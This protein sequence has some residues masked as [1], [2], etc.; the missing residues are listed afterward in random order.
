MA[1]FFESTYDPRQRSGT[2]GAEVS[3][4]NPEQAYDTDVRRLDET[5]RA[6][7]DDVDI[8]NLRQ[9]NR[10]SRFMAAAKTA[11]AYRQRASI[12]E[13]QIGGRTPRNEA[14]INGVTLPSQGDTAGPG[15][16]VGYARKP[17]PFSGTFRGF[18]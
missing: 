5:E 17:S 9:Q 7:A 18:S 14:T 15:G 10:V 12:D 6:I 3:D 13:P 4:L 16:T 11:G 2:S 1:S 8:R